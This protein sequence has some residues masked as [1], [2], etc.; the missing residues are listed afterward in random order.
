MSDLDA[1]L[2]LERRNFEPLTQASDKTVRERFESYQEGF[3]IAEIDSNP[4]GYIFVAPYRHIWEDREEI[5]SHEDLIL[6]TRYIDG[7]SKIIQFVSIAVLNKH[8]VTNLSQNGYI[9]ESPSQLLLT[10]AVEHAME[11][12]ADQIYVLAVTPQGNNILKNSGF[13]LY[14]EFDIDDEEIRLWG[15]D[16]RED[17]ESL[18]RGIEDYYERKLSPQLV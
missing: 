13:K 15:Y 5:N 14:E 12:G 8:R 7:E 3:F 2:S 9:G 18:K 11:R 4:V 16:L 10:S 6:P 17:G 1:I